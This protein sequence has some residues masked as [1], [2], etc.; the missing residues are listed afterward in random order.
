MI[1]LLIGNQAVCRL[2]D[3]GVFVPKDARVNADL[4]VE[5]I[6]GQSTKLQ[7][8]FEMTIENLAQWRGSNAPD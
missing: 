7:D 1:K 6:A 8:E 5:M 3:L 4:F 2:D